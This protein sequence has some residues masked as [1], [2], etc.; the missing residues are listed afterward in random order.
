M[1]THDATVG[2]TPHTCI[3]HEIKFNSRIKN[4]KSK[5]VYPLQT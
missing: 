4:L 5:K 3:T 1:H 2:A